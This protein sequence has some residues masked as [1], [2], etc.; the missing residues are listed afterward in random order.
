M[1]ALNG[2]DFNKCQPK[3]IS[4]E[5]HSQDVKTALDSEIANFLYLKN[6]KCIAVSQITYFFINNHINL[7]IPKVL[8][9]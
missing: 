6:Y 1:N 8:Q 9:K 3:I 4:I 5:I 2:I 7:P